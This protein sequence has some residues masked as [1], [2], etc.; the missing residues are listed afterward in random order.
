[1]IAALLVVLALQSPPPKPPPAADPPSLDE[2]LGIGGDGKDRSA[3]QR[4]SDLDRSLD[5]AKNGERHALLM[6]LNALRLH[7]TGA[8]WLFKRLLAATPVGRAPERRRRFGRRFWLQFAL[9]N[10]GQV[11]RWIGTLLRTGKDPEADPLAASQAVAGALLGAAGVRVVRRNE[12][13]P[14][15]GV[16]TLYLLSH[17][18][19]DLDPFLLLDVL[20]GHLAVVVGP[21]A[22]RWPLIDRLANVPAFV[23]TGRE[24]GVV[25]ADAIA[26]V[27]AR[28]ALA[29]YPEVTEPSYL[30]EGTPLRG[31]LIWIIQA[32]ER[33]QVIPV[34]LDDAFALGQG[35]GQVDL[36]FGPPIPCTPES[37]EGLLH[38]V[39]QFFHQHVVRM[40]DLDGP[41]VLTAV[42][43]S[44]LDAKPAAR[45]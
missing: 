12:P 29:L 3:E 5:G 44:A 27:R 20:P 1:M 21:R 35:G 34:V 15:P 39:R 19:G 11:G 43:P 8:S 6:A 10:P 13:Q 4:K 38:R 32:L 18:H 40:N 7:H 45:T 42:V 14:L 41:G 37:G 26:A 17:R 36:W 25:I 2:A 22:Q 24:R 23:L 30:G 28:R 31:G 9:K 16:P 33:S